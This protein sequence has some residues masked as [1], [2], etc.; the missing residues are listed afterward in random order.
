ML[1]IIIFLKA[2]IIGLAI[3]APVGP[4]GILCIRYNL[5][6]GFKLGI[7]V[8]LGAALADGLF[9]AI[10]GFGLITISN[11]LLDNKIILN[12]VGGSIL[13]YMGYND[14]K[15]RSNLDNPLKVKHKEF[16]QVLTTTFVL[17]LTNPLTI[18]MFLG[19]FTTLGA[20]NSNL[21]SIIY[22]ILGVFLGSLLWWLFLSSFITLTHHKLSPK[23]ITYINKTA[24]I[25]L[26]IFGC[27]TILSTI[28]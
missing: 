24:A 12:L 19:V 13:I 1:S 15:K 5:N 11:L 28:Y 2:L 3:A 9:G 6:Y 8:G 27:Y 26:I 22:I 14:L 16:L 10:A 17:T 7:A 23:V 18:I 4:I 21:Q 20:M 25:I